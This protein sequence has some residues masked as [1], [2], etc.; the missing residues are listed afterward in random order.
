[1]SSD[2]DGRLVKT[3]MIVHLE[4]ESSMLMAAA[5]GNDRRLRVDSR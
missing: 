4:G 5:T 3:E 1:M 2:A